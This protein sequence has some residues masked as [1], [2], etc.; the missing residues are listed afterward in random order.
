MPRGREREMIHNNSH[1]PS[2]PN[3]GGMPYGI[4]NQDR[5]ERNSNN[6]NMNNPNMERINNQNMNDRNERG[7][8]D[9]NDRPSPQYQRQ[10]M[11]SMHHNIS[12]SGGPGGPNGPNPMQYIPLDG[13][14][15]LIFY[16]VVMLT[17][18][19]RFIL[20]YYVYW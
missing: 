10:N 12:V 14:D 9:H 7:E 4:R 19:T 6:P 2:N 17:I 5:R 1:H 3:Q 11:G 18:S 16:I 13:S 15:F 20:L 8:R